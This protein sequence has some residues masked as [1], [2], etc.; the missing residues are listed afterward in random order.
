[1]TNL[2]DRTA[3]ALKPS[4]G[5][6]GAPKTL[7]GGADPSKGFPSEY[8]AS[9][10]FWGDLFQG[11]ESRTQQ[12]PGFGKGG[13]T[14]PVEVKSLPGDA[15]LDAGADKT[16]RRATPD[17]RIEATVKPDQITAQV[18]ELPPVSGE[19][20]VTVDQN[21][22]V[23]VEVNADWVKAT[24]RA[25]AKSGWPRSRW[26]HRGRDRA[27]SPCRGPRARRAITNPST[28]LSAPSGSRWAGLSTFRA[29]VR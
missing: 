12:L 29:G 28:R 1:M 17:Q 24:A 20:K 10:G 25:E 9:R 22:R 3:D 27:R 26:P 18:R 11:Q 5:G 16:E 14:V 2:P 21:T 23:T 4:I 13:G 19:A 6:E 15:R 7:P 8:R